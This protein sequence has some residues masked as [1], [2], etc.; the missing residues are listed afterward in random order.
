MIGVYDYCNSRDEKE[1]IEKD[2]PPIDGR[3]FYMVE[4]ERR[5]A[6]ARIFC[7]N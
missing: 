6:K 4:K 1:R 2:R 3:P 5:H 7:I